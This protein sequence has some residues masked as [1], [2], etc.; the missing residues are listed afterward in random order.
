M[1][2]GGQCPAVRWT[3]PFRFIIEVAYVFVRISDRAR[4]EIQEA[5]N[6]IIFNALVVE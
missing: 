3:E 5:L 1:L 2:P 4:A 6:E